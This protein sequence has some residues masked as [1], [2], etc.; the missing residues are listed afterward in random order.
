[1]MKSTRHYAGEILDYIKKEW[2]I[3]VDVEEHFD[4]V[5]NIRFQYMNL[6]VHIMNKTNVDGKFD[7]MYSTIN[8]SFQSTQTGMTQSEV[9]DSLVTTIELDMDL[10][11]DYQGEQT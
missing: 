3:P 8:G 11:W 9:V 1:M 5:L 6:K 4:D 2:D 7:V 10:Y